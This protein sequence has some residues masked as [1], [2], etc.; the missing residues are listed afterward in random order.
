MKYGSMPTVNDEEKKRMEDQ[1]DHMNLQAD[2][3]FDDEKAM[4]EETKPQTAHTATRRPR[5]EAYDKRVTTYLTE[6]MA[7]LVDEICRDNGISPAAA[8]RMAFSLFVQ[9]YGGR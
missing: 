4:D 9:K 6:E 7:A 5:K 1:L 8:G 3:F 2:P